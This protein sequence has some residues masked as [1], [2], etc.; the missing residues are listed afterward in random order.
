MVLKSIGEEIEDSEDENESE[1]DDEDLTFIVD[2]IIKLFQFRKNN[3]DKS[4]RK[5]KSSRKGNNEKPLIQ[6]YECKSFGHMRIECPNY[7]M[8]EK[9]KNSKD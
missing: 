4:S 9:T 2:K 3:K 5:S 7:F 6:C 8:K 1:D